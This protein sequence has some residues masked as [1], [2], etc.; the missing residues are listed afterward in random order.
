M[1][2]WMTG[3]DIPHSYSMRNSNGIVFVWC[4][5]FKKV[6]VPRIFSPR[7]CVTSLYVI[8][9]RSSLAGELTVGNHT[10]K[11]TSYVPLLHSHFVINIRW[12]MNTSNPYSA[13][14]LM[15][16]HAVFPGNIV[17][18]DTRK[19]PGAYLA[20]FLDSASLPFAPSV[21][22]CRS[23]KSELWKNNRGALLLKWCFRLECR[24]L[25]PSEVNKQR[26][27]WWDFLLRTRILTVFFFF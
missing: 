1:R 18:I 5:I 23:C 17:E 27:I 19:L 7:G 10:W 24:F 8:K 9:P 12:N 4:P 13:S 2:W 26:V 16:Y 21:V 15:Y 22:R 6:S 20:T 3:H 14:D 25:T 11:S